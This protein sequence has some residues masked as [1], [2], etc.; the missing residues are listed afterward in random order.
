MK[1]LGVVVVVVFWKRVSGF[2]VVKE[3]KVSDEFCPPERSALSAK[4]YLF[5]SSSQKGYSA[6]NERRITRMDIY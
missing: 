6:W 4:K 1:V 5:S 2:E 3:A